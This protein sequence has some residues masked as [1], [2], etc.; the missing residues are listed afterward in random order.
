MLPT[1]SVDQ[2]PATGNCRPPGCPSPGT[3]R[4]LGPLI[5]GGS[6][7]EREWQRQSSLRKEPYA[8]NETTG[9]AASSSGRGHPLHDAGPGS[10]AVRGHA[11]H[12]HGLGPQGHVSPTPPSRASHG[13]VAGR[14]RR[15]VGQAEAGHGPRC[16]ARGLP[17]P[18]T[19][20]PDFLASV[21]NRRAGLSTGNPLPACLEAVATTCA[22][23]QDS[24]CF[25]R[26]P[27]PR[28]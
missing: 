11:P 9:S 28:S 23:S 7:E 22:C 18:G 10:P 26:F 27:C 1:R 8:R 21:S 16:K 6:D 12:H 20:R 4:W 17:R 25:W 24:I 19:G 13:S 5:R 2:H 15:G 3:R 14:G